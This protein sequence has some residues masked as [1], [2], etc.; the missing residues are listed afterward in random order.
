MQPTA[1]RVSI[2]EPAAYIHRRTKRRQALDM[3]VNGANAEIAAAGH[4]RL[5]RTK[6]PKHG[7]DQIIRSADLAHQII[8]GILIAGLRTVD[9]DGGTVDKAH[10]RTELRQNSQEHIG[11][12]D[13][14][15]IFAADLNLTMEGQAAVDYILFQN[16]HLPTLRKPHLGDS[17]K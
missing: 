15:N 7:T 8:G 9:L 1:H 5:G 14:G 16:S 4:R 17:S 10:L 3:L 12:T 11:I 13:L 2:D 6:T